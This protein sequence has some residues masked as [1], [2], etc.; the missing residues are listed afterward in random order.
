MII[1]FTV[2]W[3]FHCSVLDVNFFMNL[4]PSSRHRH[5][6]CDSQHML[7][8]QFSSPLRDFTLEIFVR[9]FLHIPIILLIKSNRTMHGRMAMDFVH[10]WLH[11]TVVKLTRSQCNIYQLLINDECP[12]YKIATS[13][14]NKLEK[15]PE[16]CN[17]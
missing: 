15:I 7:I 17:A 8:N 6:M 12:S 9:I 16:L 5:S 1:P 4:H 11:S 14:S 2:H 3:I 10:K 13:K